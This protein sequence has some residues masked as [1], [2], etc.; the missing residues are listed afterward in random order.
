MKMKK[1]LCMFLAIMML[2]GLTACGGEKEAELEVKEGTPTYADDKQMEM[3]AY[4]GPRR[5]G[6]RYWGGVYGKHPDDPVEGWE[7]WITREAF[8]DYID[9]GF[10]YLFPEQDGAYDATYKNGKYKTVTNFKDS[11]LY[12]YME[13]AEEMNI[14][15][16][17]FSSKLMTLASSTDS[18]ISDDDKAYL[19]QMVEDLSQYK[20]FKGVTLRDEP[21]IKMAKATGAVVDYLNSLKPDM[22]YFTSCLPIYINNIETLTTNKTDSLEEAYRDYID[23]FSEAI[24]TFSYDGYPL[25]ENSALA[26]TS[27]RAEWFQN[28]KLLAEQAKANKFDAGITIQSHGFDVNS[29][30][31]YRPVNTKADVAFQ[32]YT[33]LAYGMK[34]VNYYTYWQHWID[35]EMVSTA[36]VNYPEKNGEAPIKTDTYYAVK[37]VNW[38]VKKFDHVFLNFDW[39][40]T[41]SLVPEGK[42]ASTTLSYVGDYKNPRIA[43]ASATE[44]A[45]IGCMKDKDGYDGYWIVNATD[46]GKLLSNSVTVEF[47]KASKAIA[48]IKGEEQEITLKDGKYTFEL[49][50]GDGV[51]VIPIV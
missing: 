11:D 46:P 39:Q 18:R 33:S 19:S 15:V 1:W 13:L 22:Y 27:V 21:S 2:T 16:V 48:Y 50:S 28:L 32:M 43:S 8:Q 35:Y 29:T 17:V 26:Q 25:I 12:P 4:C 44:E 5:E 45:I 31:H 7:G 37:D 20:C 40:G 10:T 3:A 34:Y 30:F 24:G 47:K 14:P 49:E 36:M 6:Y 38:E 23:A 42:N 9:C 51:F 41:M